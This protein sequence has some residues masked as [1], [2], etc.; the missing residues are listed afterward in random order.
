MLE[1][2]LSGAQAHTKPSLSTKLPPVPSSRSHNSGL[3]RRGRTARVVQQE[4]PNGFI[5]PREV[6]IRPKLFGCAFYP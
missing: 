3:G 4:G 6:E 2:L 1:E 5:N